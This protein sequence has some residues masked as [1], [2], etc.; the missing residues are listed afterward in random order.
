MGLSKA[1]LLAFITILTTTATLIQAGLVPT[2]GRLGEDCV[3]T[4]L[5]GLSCCFPLECGN[6]FRCQAPFVIHRE[7][8]SKPPTIAPTQAPTEP[9][10]TLSAQE[11]LAAAL[12][13]LQN[14]APEV[15]TQAPL[16]E[17]TNP[18]PKTEP[19]PIPSPSPTKKPAVTLKPQQPVA[20]PDSQ[21]GVVCD[22]SRLG[23][24]CGGKGYMGDACCPTGAKCV[25]M[26]EEG[27]FYCIEQR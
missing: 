24:K 17:I 16:K 18:P 7:K 15:A 3:R 9:P 25:A 21:Y 22:P 13:L 2:C 14:P 23:K 8:H 1:I 5:N 26:G 20:Y 4:S 10:K 27:N 12:G 19:S 11:L 6:D